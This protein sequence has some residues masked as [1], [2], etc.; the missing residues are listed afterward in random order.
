MNREG[1]WYDGVYWFCWLRTRSSVNKMYRFM[2][3]AVLAIIHASAFYLNPDVSGIG[4]CLRLQ[5]KTIH[6]VSGQETN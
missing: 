1:I 2:T 3:M 6:M 5:L 4:F